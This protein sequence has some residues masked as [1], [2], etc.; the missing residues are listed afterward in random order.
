MVGGHM[1]SMK[2]HA[3]ASTKTRV[4]KKEGVYDPL[5]EDIKKGLEDIKHGRTSIWKPKFI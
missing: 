4:E 1:T 2:A 3:M 5:W